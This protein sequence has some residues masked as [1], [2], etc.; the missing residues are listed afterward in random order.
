MPHSSRLPLSHVP[1]SWP[2]R[3][4][5]PAFIGGTLAGMSVWSVL[6]AGLGGAGR[7]L[8]DSGEDLGSVFAG[9]CA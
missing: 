2:L 3:P 8:L 5:L 4:Q 7:S 6:Y 1:H 9:E